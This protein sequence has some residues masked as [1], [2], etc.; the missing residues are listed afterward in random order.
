[1]KVGHLKKLLEGLD[2]DVTIELEIL[3]TEN[4]VASAILKE[5]YDES[6]GW[7]T[8]LGEERGIA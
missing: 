6:I 8:L 2:D 1:M 5:I 4:Q 7:I 3:T